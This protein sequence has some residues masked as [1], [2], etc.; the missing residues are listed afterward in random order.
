MSRKNF[1]KSGKKAAFKDRAF[2][3]LSFSVS[4]D[5]PSLVKFVSPLDG[6]C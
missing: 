1:P 2:F 6:V 4:A 3:R 5:S